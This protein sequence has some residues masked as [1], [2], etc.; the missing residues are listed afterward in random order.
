MGD[1]VSRRDFLR[2]PRSKAPPKLPPRV[3][4]PGAVAER[5]FL[6]RCT[7]CMD[8]IEACPHNAIHTL[9]K[10]VSPGAG[11]PVMVL[12]ARACH[13]CEGFPCA[14][15][16]PEQ[17]LLVPSEPVVRY[18]TVRV[19]PGRCLPFLGPECGACAGLCPTGAEGALRLQ[20]GRPMI[21][22]EACVGCGLCVEACVVRPSAIELRAGPAKG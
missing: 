2:R 14:A 16:C 7:A 19:D 21:D 4:P 10:H 8:C 20:R 5:E 13:M 12:D 22:D 9:A 3:R 6:A 17:A 11:T 18:G 1:N 15:A